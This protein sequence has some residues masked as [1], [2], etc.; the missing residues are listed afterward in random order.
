MVMS[1]QISS[2]G[3]MASLQSR[4]DNKNVEH[5][6][7]LDKERNQLQR[8]SFLADQVPPNNT[9]HCTY[10]KRQDGAEA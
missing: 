3:H 2:P 4:F 10:Y 6:S 5:H 1:D 7:N 8:S 9:G